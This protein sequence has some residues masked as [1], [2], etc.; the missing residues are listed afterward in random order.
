[1]SPFTHQEACRLLIHNLGKKVSAFSMMA[2]KTCLQA[3]P[4]AFKELAFSLKRQERTWT[5]EIFG[6]RQSLYIH[7]QDPSLH[8][9][10]IKLV[11]AIQEEEWCSDLMPL[12]QS[13]TQAFPSSA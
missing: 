11:Q 1:M 9:L 12:A 4:R 7:V 8:Q 3:R 6:P 2:C 10:F 5:A 13:G